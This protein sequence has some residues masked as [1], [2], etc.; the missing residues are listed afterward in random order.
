MATGDP[1]ARRGEVWFADVPG[2]KRPVLVLSRDPMGRILRSVI[3]VPITSRKRGLA[4]EI[5]L[6]PDAGLAHESV[7]NFDNTF[8]LARHR[9]VRRLGRASR[10]TMDDACRALA[11]ATG[12]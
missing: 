7:A 4:T 10:T 5:V 9:L 8:L 2:K 12:C 1:A 11:A 6:G 3:C